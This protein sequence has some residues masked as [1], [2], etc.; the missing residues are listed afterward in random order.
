[1]LIS[2]KDKDLPPAKV[3][4]SMSNLIV[5]LYLRSYKANKDR[6][7]LFKIEA[8]L[9][10]CSH[11]YIFKDIICKNTA[12]FLPKYVGIFC[13]SS[14][15]SKYKHPSFYMYYIKGENLR[16]DHLCFKRK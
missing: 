9:V 3:C 2:F 5:M 8:S 6:A 7:S 14:V 11:T 15:Y 4:S 13:S 1:M 12:V 16:H 10:T